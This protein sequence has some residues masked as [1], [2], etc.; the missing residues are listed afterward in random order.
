MSAF[1]IESNSGVIVI[2]LIA[3][4]VAFGIASK[5]CE[6]QFVIHL[7][8]FVS[9]LFSLNLSELCNPTNLVPSL[10]KT[11]YKFRIF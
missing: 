3:A 5:I 2:V 7:K 8:Q 6:R 9:S 10:F 4:L 1:L 11:Y